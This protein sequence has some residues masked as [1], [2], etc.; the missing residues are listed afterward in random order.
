MPLPRG[1][2]K[3]KNKSAPKRPTVQNRQTETLELCDDLGLWL[4]RELAEESTSISRRLKETLY[5]VEGPLELSYTI[6]RDRFNAGHTV[7][8][9]AE[10]LEAILVWLSPIQQLRVRAVCRVFRNAIDASPSIRKAMLRDADMTIQRPIASPF[11]TILD[12]V[13]SET[14][15]SEHEAILAITFKERCLEE[16][17]MLRT[18]SFLKALAI[19]QPPPK[20]AV[21]SYNC[22]TCADCLQLGRM[23]ASQI[24]SISHCGSCGLQESIRTRVQASHSWFDF[25]DAIEATKYAPCCQCHCCLRYTLESRRACIVEGRPFQRREERSWT[26]A[27]SY[28]CKEETSLAIQGCST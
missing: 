27:F 11:I 14:R 13:D 19:A 8:A 24:P 6:N 10:L 25:G 9:T 23:I 4:L 16:S 15:W 12:G 21:V 1:I 22:A 26:I 2:C 28:A 3:A 5:T 20:Y 7:F 17:S 18:N